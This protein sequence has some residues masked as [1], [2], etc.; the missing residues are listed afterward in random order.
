M[1]KQA[2]NFGS[3]PLKTVGNGCGEFRR[4]DHPHKWGC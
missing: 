1:K 3:L 2:Q 4:A